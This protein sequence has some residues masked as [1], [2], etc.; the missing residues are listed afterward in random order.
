MH[1]VKEEEAK[2]DDFVEKAVSKIN[3]SSVF[4][5]YGV[6]LMVDEAGDTVSLHLTSVVDNEEEREGND[7]GGKIAAIVPGRV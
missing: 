4:T 1:Q 5:K 3:H 2:A 6:R 7:D